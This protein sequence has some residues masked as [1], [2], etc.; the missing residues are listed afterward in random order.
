MDVK[1]WLAMQS[2]SATSVFHMGNYCHQWKASTFHTGKPS[3]H[4][5]MNGH[6]WLQINNDKKRRKLNAGDMVFFFTNIPFYIMSSEKTP[7]TELP[8]REM[9]SFAEKKEESTSLICGFLNAKLRSLEL[10]FALMPEFIIINTHCPAY[11]RLSSLLQLL[12]MECIEVDDTCEIKITRL[13]DLLL[14]YLLE[15]ATK[16]QSLDINLIKLSDNARF[17]DLILTIHASPQNSWSVESMA[18]H[19]HMS[20]STFIRKTEE[21][22][23]YTPN[24]MLTRIRINVAQK[25][26]Q[27]GCPIERIAADVGYHSSVGFYKAFRRTTGLPPGQ[28]S[29]Q[30]QRTIY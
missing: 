14:V 19:V 13:T 7:V 21:L 23:G 1:K 30:L 16:K 20:R 4:I 12:R 26:I 8:A 17:L 27:R 22:S 10:L 29:S 9:L 25:L 24:E 18:E 15:E 11:N 6:C 5:V 2:D 3:F 28:W